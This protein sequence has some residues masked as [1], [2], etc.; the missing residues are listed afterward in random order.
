MSSPTIV[1]LQVA[2]KPEDGQIVDVGPYTHSVI[3]AGDSLPSV[4]RYCNAC[5]G[6]FQRKG[7]RDDRPCWTCGGCG[8]FQGFESPTVE[9]WS[10][11]PGVTQF[12]PL[13]PGDVV[14]I[15]VPAV[16]P[17]VEENPLVAALLDAL[18]RSL[19][20]ANPVRTVSTEISRCEPGGGYTIV[21]R[22]NGGGGAP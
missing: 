3:W 9:H 4:V 7:T 13:K 22:I 19:D 17:P 14:S 10:G 12:T 15:I 1:P 21:M 5:G 6:A 2:V 11:E 16:V 18:R 20:P 8:I